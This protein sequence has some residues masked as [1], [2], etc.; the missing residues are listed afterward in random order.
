[1]SGGEVAPA[2]HLWDGADAGDL[3]RF[4]PTPDDD[5]V[6]E[7]IS[8]AEYE[9]GRLSGGH[10][11]VGTSVVA[12]ENV[13]IVRDTKVNCHERALATPAQLAQPLMGGE[14]VGQQRHAVHAQEPVTVSGA[15]PD[16][17][18][19]DA[20]GLHLGGQVHE[21]RHKAQSGPPRPTVGRCG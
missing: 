3:A 2:D 11:S 9:A 1:M 15:G 14:E 10:L 7:R 20:L 16:T 8:A 5:L 17:G 19:A 6:P 18:A 4:D 21:T 13:L 12:D